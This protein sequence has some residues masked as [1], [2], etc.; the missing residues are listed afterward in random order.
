MKTGIVAGSFDPITNGHLDIIKRALKIFDKIII[1]VSTN[2]EKKYMFNESDR[3]SSIKE[4]LAE[5]N[6]DVMTYKG[7]LA[8]F[9]KSQNAVLVK[10][11]RNASD[12]DYEKHMYEVNLST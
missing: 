4:A 2:S 9:V 11:A 5:Y 8:D 6:I 7:L 10:G 12:F 3:V 1:A